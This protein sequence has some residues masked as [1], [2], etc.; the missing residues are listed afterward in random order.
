MR[1]VEGGAWL[2]KELR[3][4]LSNFLLLSAKIVSVDESFLR[5]AA[6]VWV[7]VVYINPPSVDKFVQDLFTWPGKTDAKAQWSTLC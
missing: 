7:M 3:G 5:V 4:I 1:H 2:C 6:K